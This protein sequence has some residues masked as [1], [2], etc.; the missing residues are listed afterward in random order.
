MTIRQ[1][2]HCSV[3]QIDPPSKLHLP[4]DAVSQPARGQV[5]KGEADAPKDRALFRRLAAWLQAGNDF[6]QFSMNRSGTQACTSHRSHFHH[7]L[8]VVDHHPCSGESLRGTS[9]FPG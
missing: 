4:G 6:P 9:H 8:S 2:C 3:Q 5:L 7:D 1:R